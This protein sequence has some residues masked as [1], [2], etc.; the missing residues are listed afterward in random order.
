MSGPD[1]QPN[2]RRRNKSSPWTVLPKGREGP[3]PSLGSRGKGRG[4]LKPTRE[5]WNLWWRSPMATQWS[6]DDLPSL[7]IMASAY[8]EALRSGARDK[9][10]EFRQW[11]DRFGLSPRARLRNRW[12][13]AGEEPPDEEGQAAGEQS[14]AAVVR[15]TVVE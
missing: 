10:A 6:A 8:D 11:A 3:I 14:D 9:L 5:A 12:L 1:P 15:L 7:R 4:W 13:L 2:A